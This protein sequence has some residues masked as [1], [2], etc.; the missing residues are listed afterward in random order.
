VAQPP[1]GETAPAPQAPQVEHRNWVDDPYAPHVTEGK[2]LRIGSVVGDLTIDQ[3]KYSG[4][5]GVIALGRRA[6]RF[7]FDVEYSFM[8]LQDP[9]PSAI[10]VGRAQDLALVGRFDLIRLG[11]HVVGANSMVAFYAEGALEESAY[12]YDLP[13]DD[14]PRLV[15]ED[16]MRSKAAVGFG[17]MIDH[18][19]EQPLGF[20]SRFG[21]RLGWRLAKSPRDQHDAMVACHGCLAAMAPTPMP[22]A[23][24]TEMILE[25]TLDFTW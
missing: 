15:P 22:R 12:H 24:D 4:I 6:G 16:N 21:W 8:R 1:P 2:L 18:R 11:P 17:A 7:S 10:A 3:R 23:Y 14:A 13:P 5:G 9:G 19:I 20:P 25:S